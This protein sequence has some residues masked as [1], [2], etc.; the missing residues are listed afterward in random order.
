MP[1]LEDVARLAGVSRATASRILSA[2]DQSRIPFAQDTRE[3]V[4]QA[5]IMLDYKPNRQA[6]GLVSARTH[7]V[8][9]LIPGMGESFSSS[10]VTVA[11]RE[12]AALGY[13]VLLAN[14]DSDNVM[15]QASIDE[16]LSWRVD[17][18]LIL[19]T[20]NTGDAEKLWL[21]WHKGIPFVLIDR[22]F[23]ETPF[24]SVTTDDYSGAVMAVEHLLSVGRRRIAFAT[25]PATVST[26]R[27]R[28]AGYIDTLARH[29]VAFDP[30]LVLNVPPSSEGGRI[31]V[32]ELMQLSSPPDALFCCT[33]LVAVGAMEEC[34]ALDIRIPEDLALVGYSD[35]DFCRVLRSP[36][37]TVHQPP[38]LM[39]QC[40]ARMLAQLMKGE[41]PE[42]AQVKL[43]VSL[44][45]RESA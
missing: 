11:Q 19:P 43:P 30:E 10:I 12:L 18:L 38:A 26:N 3:R 40:A 39:A 13:G 24:Y 37:T 20:Q 21:L 5:A 31:A 36:L 23:A 2:D 17:G 44:V 4:R 9:L 28:R 34:M 14:T 25:R 35:L 6:R 8:G 1:T 22:L 29:G 33:D 41:T 42:V 7:I 16:F 45:V 15:E 32:R 27:L